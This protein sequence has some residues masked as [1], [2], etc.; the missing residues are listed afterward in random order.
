MHEF[1]NVERDFS[2]FFGLFQNSVFFPLNFWKT[3]DNNFQGSLRKV[4]LKEIM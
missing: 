1:E 3:V 2:F 4:F